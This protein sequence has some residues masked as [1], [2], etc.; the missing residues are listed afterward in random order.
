MAKKFPNLTYGELKSS[1][2]GKQKTT[3]SDK[4]QGL[5]GAVIGQG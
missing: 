5:I 1:P 3:N 4:L 2:Q